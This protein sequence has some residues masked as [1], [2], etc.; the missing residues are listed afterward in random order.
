MTDGIL[1]AETQGDR[2]LNRYDTIIIDEAH[3]RSLNID[4]L[5]GYLKGLLPQRPDLRIIIT[6]ATIDPDRFSKHFADAPI[7]EVSGRTYPIDIRYAR[8][9]PK[10]PDDQDRDQSKPAFSD[11]I[12]EHSSRR[13]SG[14]ILVFCHRRARHPRHR[15]SSSPP[16][17]ATATRSSPSTRACLTNEEQ[18]RIFSPHT[19]RRVVLAT[20]VAETSL[21]VP[22]IKY[23]I[24]TGLARISRFGSA[25][26][27]IRR[28]PIEK[29]SQ[30]SANQRAGRCG[31]VGPGIMHPPLRTRRF[32]PPPRIHRPRDQAHQPRRRHPPDGQP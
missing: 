1:L 21:T 24:D 4:F 31:R 17:T 3:E 7:I 25:R 13:P 11:A 23:V 22:G 30:A 29:I 26:T 14:D 12:D 28:L 15:R 2:F 20:N 16:P 9:S 8:P 18:Q 27:R 10:I 32:R 19:K 5:L 6:S